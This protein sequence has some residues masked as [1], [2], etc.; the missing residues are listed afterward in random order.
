MSSQF[1]YIDFCA[2]FA[3]AGAVRLGR[4]GGR[5]GPAGIFGRARRAARQEPPPR[6][7]DTKAPTNFV[8]A[9]R[10]AAKKRKFAFL[11]AGVNGFIGKILRRT[12]KC[13]PSGRTLGRGSGLPIFF[14]RCGCA[15][16]RL[17]HP[18]AAIFKLIF[19]IN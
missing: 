18:R 5:K 11:P 14:C 17:P 10:L 7:P 19:L 16:D 3:P 4:E 6:A 15:A 8:T 2:F 1:F 12:F 13:E 9:R